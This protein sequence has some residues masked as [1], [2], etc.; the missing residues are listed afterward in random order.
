MPWTGS[1][2]NQ[3]FS[4]TDGV[5]SGATV[6]QQQEAAGLNVDATLLDVE[7][8]DMAQ[9]IS[10][11]LKKDGGTKPTAN[12]D[13]NN[14]KLTGL[15][16]ATASGDALHYGQIGSAV[17][18]YSAALAS[19]ASVA[20]A[21][22]LIPYTTGAS[23]WGSTALTA[24]ARTLLDDASQADAQATLGLVPGTNVQAQSASLADIAGLTFAA[25]DLLTHDG[26]DLVRRAKHT[27]SNRGKWL[28]Q[29]VAG[30]VK[31]DFEAVGNW[32]IWTTADVVEFSGTFIPWDD[33]APGAAEGDALWSSGSLLL[34]SGSVIKI[35]ADVY[36]GCGGAA[37]DIGEV[38]IFV[39]STCIGFGQAAPPDTDMAVLVPAR[40]AYTVP[41]TG[42]YTFSVRW[43]RG[44]A[45]TPPAYLNANSLGARKGGGA[46]KSMVEMIEYLPAAEE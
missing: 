16:N 14:K 27:N 6:Y 20:S 36:I 25:G 19:M 41:S 45:A 42:S 35:A 30:A 34:M 1:T 37:D 46:M 15:A 38:A 3:T 11:C 12:I 10:E 28:K 8:Q 40:A 7:Q 39:G 9:A 33:T 13:M 21:A 44:T 4:R 5:R 24:F 22:D 32:A 23:T 26:T 29:T 17:Q 18:A 31:W 2:G 43:G